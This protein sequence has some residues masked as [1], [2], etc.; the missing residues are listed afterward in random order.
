MRER[1]RRCCGPCWQ[2][3]FS[4][5]CYSVGPAI[6]RSMPE[7]YFSFLALVLTLH[8]FLPK[9]TGISLVTAPLNRAAE[10]CIY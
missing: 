10:P 7:C 5:F 9:Y 8:F 6:Y 4:V 1:E 2:S 3:A